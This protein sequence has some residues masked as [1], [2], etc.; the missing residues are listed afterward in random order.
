MLC[1]MKS[2]E[3]LTTLNIMDKPQSERQTEWTATFTKEE[4]QLICNS[5]KWCLLYKAE[6]CGGKPLERVQTTWRSIRAK[7]EAGDDFLE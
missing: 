2:Y 5:G 7:L 4:R 1:A 6:V 3:N